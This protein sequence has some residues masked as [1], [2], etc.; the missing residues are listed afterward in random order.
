MH[1]ASEQTANFLRTVPATAG[2]QQPEHHADQRDDDRIAPPTSTR[3]AAEEQIVGEAGT[4][5]G[6]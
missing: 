2:Q 3:V 4:A 1:A 6:N 5:A